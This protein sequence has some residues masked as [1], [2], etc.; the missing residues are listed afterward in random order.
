MLQE[1]GF[2]DGLP[3]IP[4]IHQELKRRK[5]LKFNSLMEKGKVVGNH[6]LVREFYANAFHKKGAVADFK[7]YVRG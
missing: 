3:E 2:Y 7:V 1:K 4:A 5:W 6:R